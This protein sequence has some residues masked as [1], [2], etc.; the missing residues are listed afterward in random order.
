[1][2]YSSTILADSPT[3]YWRLGESG[4]T[5][6]DT[7][8]NGKTGTYT[9][10]PLQ[11]QATLIEDDLSFNPDTS[12]NQYVIST[13]TLNISTASVE[14]WFDYNGTVPASGHALAIAGFGAPFSGVNDKDL[15]I[16][17]AGRVN[18]YV[19]DGAVKTAVGP[20]LA[21]GVHHLV[22]TIDGT[23]AYLYVDGSRL[24]SVLASGSY[25]SYAANN[26]LVGSEWS[27]A[28]SGDTSV[29]GRRDEFAVYSTALTSDQILTHYRVGRGG[30][31]GGGVIGS[32]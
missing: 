13:F 23:T 15:F 2:T 28:V 11:Q 27:N 21:T 18:F 16:D 8:G 31:W 30:L 24:G 20:V 9:G 7:S 1:M 5:A 22:G 12:N 14:V 3:L 4:A 6:A 29:A 10:S 32:I 17:S 19:Y 26:V 25:T